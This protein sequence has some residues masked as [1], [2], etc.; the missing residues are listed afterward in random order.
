MALVATLLWGS[1]FPCIKLGYQYFGITNN[2]YGSMLL[3][4]GIRFSM[5]GVTTLIIGSIK[6]KRVMLPN[7]N[8]V[9]PL[10]SLGFVLTFMQY[11]FYYIGMAH[12]TGSK[13]SILNSLS[14]IFC[15]IVAHFFY[16]NDKLSKTTFMGCIFCFIGVLMVNI[17]KDSNLSGGFTLLGDGLLILSA[18]SVA[19]G[20]LINKEVTRKQDPVMVTGYHLFIGGVLLCIVGGLTGGRLQSNKPVAILLIIYMILIS[21]VAFTIWSFLLK[22]NAMGKVSIYKFLIP[23]FGTILSATLYNR[24]RTL[25]LRAI[26]WSI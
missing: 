18:L 20:D 8:Q 16:K 10:V 11:V 24:K 15:V 3:F 5:A 19:F 13:G 22:Y 21:S 9:L 23:I 26:P 12:V 17:M 4:A 14:T 7:R 25:S 1:A 2:Q 6:V